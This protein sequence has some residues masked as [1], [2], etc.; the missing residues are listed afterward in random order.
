[1]ATVTGYTAERMKEIEDAAIVGGAVVGDNLILT[2]FDEI[3]IDAGVVVGPQGDTGPTGPP[4]GGADELDELT[5]VNLAG[6]ADGMVL[7]RVGG[8]WVPGTIVNLPLTVRKTLDES[9]VSN[10]TLQDDDHLKFAALANKKYI[11]NWDLTYDGV[12]AG[13]IRVDIAGP[14]GVSGWWSAFGLQTGAAAEDNQTV[15]SSGGLSVSTGGAGVSFGATGVGMS[16]LRIFATII[17]STTPGD[18]RLRWSQAVSNATATRVMGTNGASILT[19]Q[20]TT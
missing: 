11:A 4:G 5:D 2:R 12:A 8:V 10:A 18:I 1:M 17:L 15:R 6:Q 9:V 19:Y 16:V 7:I 3:T 13:D 14:T 20:E